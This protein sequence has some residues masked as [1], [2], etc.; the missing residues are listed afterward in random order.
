MHRR[1]FTLIEL[2]VVIAVIGLLST[3]AVV[4]LGQARIK[5][6]DVKRMADLKQISTAI[7]LYLNNNNYLPRNTAG[8]CTYISDPTN[9][10]GA[11]FQSDLASY[12]A[13]VPL[14]PVNKN[15]PTDY[16]YK[17]IDNVGKYVLCAKLENATGNSYDYSACGDG[18]GVYNYCIYPNGQ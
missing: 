6:R 11:A 16:F 12:I 13:N 15:K 17:N 1:A 14:D 7:E 3:I 4:S 18:V 9:G 10:Y 5:A 8:W 2:L